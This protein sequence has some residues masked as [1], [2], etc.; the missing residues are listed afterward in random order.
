MNAGLYMDLD[1]SPAQRKWLKYC[2]TNW[3]LYFFFGTDR[4]EKYG[5]ADLHLLTK[6]VSQDCVL[7]NL[8]PSGLN[9]LVLIV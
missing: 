8:D 9:M 3:R 2:R 6:T 1:R 5:N 7:L 4:L